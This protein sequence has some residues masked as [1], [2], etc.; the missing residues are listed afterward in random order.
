M[1]LHAEE[2]A[3]TVG[4]ASDANQPNAGA[5]KAEDDKD[6]PVDQED[7]S[8]ETEQSKV[9]ESIEGLVKMPAK[10]PKHEDIIDKLLEEESQEE[11][12]LEELF[13]EAEQE[14]NQQ[15]QEE[16]SQE[17]LPIPDETEIEELDIDVD[18]DEVVPLTKVQ[19][20]EQIK[21]WLT[22]NK[23]DAA[24]IAFDELL[25][26][27][28]DDLSLHIDHAIF[29]YRHKGDLENAKEQLE[30]IIEKDRKKPNAFLQLARI[31]EQ[32]HDFLLAKSYYEKAYSL[33]K[34]IAG[35][36]F[37]LGFINQHYLSDKAQVATDYFKKAIKKNKEHAESHYQLA[38]L[39][40]E[41]F[42]ETDKAIK[43]FRKTL[44][45]QPEHPFANYDLAIV[46]HQLGEL[47]LAA[48]YYRKAYAIN[49]ELKT[50]EN[51]RAFSF[52]HTAEQS[53]KQAIGNGKTL[54]GEHE[55]T[56]VSV[57]EPE[58]DSAAVQLAEVPSNA[59]SRPAAKEKMIAKPGPD[60]P[61]ANPMLQ[62]TVMI[63]GATAGIG[64]A[65]ATLFAQQGYR[66]ILTGRRNEK[67]EALKTKLAASTNAQLHTL[68]FD[69]RDQAAVQKVL[70]KLPQDWRE[71]DILINN[72]GLA[73]GYAP[74]H[75]GNIEDWETMLDTNVKGL[76]Y[77]T[78][79]ISPYMVE[80][81]EGHI[82]N[83]CSTA[84]REVYPNGNVYCATKFAVDAIT[85]SMRLDLY[86]HGIRV[87]Q[88]SP[89]HVEET[90]FAEVRFDGDKKRA[91]IYEDFQPLKSTDVAEAIYFIA[92]RPPYVNIQD[93]L[94]MGSQQAGNNHIDRSGRK[95]R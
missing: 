63:T 45:L 44:K 95:D 93:I 29:L 37:K 88:V 26:D 2:S 86:K 47:E 43:H 84:G 61:P 54:S 78:R 48:E 64:R 53:T 3:E 72:A 89:G 92:T 18:L 34:N 66:L 60:A 82:I 14:F 5:A 77:M 7:N 40:N 21:A 38:I 9:I 83:V 32:Q 30:L 91:K 28:P 69:V 50:P 46:Y 67:L 8:G 70:N 55:S 74:I 4:N 19:R 56:K 6:L 33:D 68:N 57:L 59:A 79:L 16:E 13:D 87:S 15:A 73:K 62:K 11:G 39:Y 35:I 31:A 71:I 42:Q 76:L 51:D 65:T 49:P 20:F 80:R 81:R 23:L 22:Q 52:T 10:P 25:K 58:V 90:E 41:H 94:M 17:I 75:E 12:N 27:Y 1:E 36:D 85:K 24:E